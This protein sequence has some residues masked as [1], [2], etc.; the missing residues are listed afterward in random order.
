MARLK[1]PRRW[2]PIVWVIIVSA[3]LNVTAIWWGLPNDVSW[4]PDEVWPSRVFDGLTHLFSNG[5][6]DKYPPVHFYALGVVLL[7]F[8]ALDHWKVVD[9]SQPRA[10]AAII[11]AF[12][13]LT[14]IM[15]AGLIYLIFLCG[16]ELI[17]KRGA[18]WAA[19]ITALLAPFP[20]YAKTANLDVPYLFWFVWSLYFYIRLFKTHKTRYYLLFAL[21]AVLSIATKDQAAGLYVLAP[22]AILWADWTALKSASPGIAVW[23]RFPY[24]NYLKATGVAGAA[25]LGGFNILFNL[26][27]FVDHAKLIF[28]PASETYQEIPQT[29]AGYGRLLELT[30]H[31]IRFCLGWPFFLVC[32]AGIALALVRKPRPG[33]LL[34]LVSFGVSY[35]IFFIGL[36]RIPYARFFF[37]VA[38]ILSLFG[39]LAIDE[40][41]KSRFRAAAYIVVTAAT[42]FALLTVAAVDVFMLKDSRYDVE[43]WM[44]AHLKPG[45]T[46]GAAT[47]A[48]YLPLHGFPGEYDRVVDRRVRTRTEARRRRVRRKIP[49]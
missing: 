38:I 7:P 48:E 40:A 17:G 44:R 15:A 9:F 3:G 37:P 28:G 24:L 19:I 34:S 13:L 45:A 30:I 35:L 25:F 22:L 11:V 49:P 27:G 20:Y 2:S 14:V 4:A 23:R 47:L 8:F 29:A 16:R 43:R 26:R 32:L 41:L 31:N 18:L 39:G 10:A 46:V 12:R 36:S 6:S 5:W 1:A 33:A 42:A 21:T